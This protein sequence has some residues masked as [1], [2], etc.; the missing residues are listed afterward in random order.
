M[1]DV[2]YNLGYFDSALLFIYSYTKQL[3]YAYR[4]VVIMF[5]KAEV[6]TLP[7]PFSVFS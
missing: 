3:F 2:L 1:Y 5:V 7:V 4:G 6:L